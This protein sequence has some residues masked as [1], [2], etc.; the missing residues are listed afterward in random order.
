MPAIQSANDDAS[1]LAPSPGA[2]KAP[3]DAPDPPEFR[4][5]VS[6]FTLVG[7]PRL[8]PERSTSTST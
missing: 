1:A 8:G 6:A 7:V 4:N 2:R 5:D 3:P